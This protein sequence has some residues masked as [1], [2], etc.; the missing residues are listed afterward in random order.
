VTDYPLTLRDREGNLTDVLYNASVYTD[1]QGN[2]QGV[3]AAARDVSVLKELEIQRRIA[4]TLQQTLLDLPPAIPG[5][6]YGHLYRSATAEAAV[7]GDFFDIFE[8]KKGRVGLLIGDVAGHGVEAARMSTLVKDTIRAFAHQF[9]RPSVILRETN[10]LL[11]E[12]RIPGFVTI[13]LGMLD[14]GTGLLVYSLAGHPY[15]LRRRAGGEVEELTGAAVPLGVFPDQSWKEYRVQL[16][17]SDVLLLYTDGASEVRRDGRFFGEAGLIETLRRHGGG[18]PEAL[19]ALVLD[20][21]LR[22]SGGI[23]SDDVALLAVGLRPAGQPDGSPGRSPE[24]R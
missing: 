15:P 5:V 12:R 8:A 7:G 22:F 19:P 9:R 11:L 3:F 4:G 6:A 24:G 18:S 1:P 21:V 13:F 17:P 14:R 10:Q 16:D 20:E 23:L 2:V